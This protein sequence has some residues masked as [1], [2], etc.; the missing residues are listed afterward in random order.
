[1]DETENEWPSIDTAYGFV[2]PSY[3]LLT[4]RFEAADSRLG[5]LMTTAAALTVAAPAAARV[6]NPFVAFDSPLFLGAAGLFVV[7]MTCGLIARITGSLTLP[8]PRII[9]E[10][11]LAKPE[12]KFKADALSIS[13][14]HFDDNA[15][16]I[17]AKGN[18]SIALTVMLLIEVLLLVAWLTR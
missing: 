5:S 4:S 11:A 14:Q 17:N 10:T 6:V 9:H 7:L 13:G 1:M 16:V 15:R 12:W 3:Q 8:N 18:W 2:L